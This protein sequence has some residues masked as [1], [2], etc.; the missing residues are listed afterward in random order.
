MPGVSATNEITAS[1]GSASSSRI[2]TRLGDRARVANPD[3]RIESV[4]LSA[5]RIVQSDR[6]GRL[7]ADMKLLGH[8]DSSCSGRGSGGGF[9]VTS[10]L[11][12]VA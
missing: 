8:Q 11:P 6:R 2:E 1:R 7:L 4:G 5:L 12:A 3:D 9:L 10:T